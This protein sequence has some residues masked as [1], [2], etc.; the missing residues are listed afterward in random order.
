LGTVKTS[1]G[2]KAG[3][4]P[5]KKPKASRTYGALFSKLANS[6]YANYVKEH[7][8]AYATLTKTNQDELKSV[9]LIFQ[10][11]AETLARSSH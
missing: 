3:A 6:S 10:K 1:R 9:R 5:L 7:A 11:A 2:G 4:T 8:R